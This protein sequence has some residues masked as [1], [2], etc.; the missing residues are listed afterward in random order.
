MIYK[1]AKCEFYFE[2]KNEPSKCPRCEN[3]YIIGAS[4]REREEF[5]QKHGKNKMES[6]ASKDYGYTHIED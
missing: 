6:T 5:V 3:Q 1:C 4:S 2:R